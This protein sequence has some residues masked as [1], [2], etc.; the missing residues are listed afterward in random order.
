MDWNK[1]IKIG[2]IGQIGEDIASEYL[3]KNSWKILVRNY[4]GKLG[5]ID[6]VA[7]RG[8]KTLVFFEI[9]TIYNHE[10]SKFM[11]E[12]NLSMAKLKKLQRICQIF[13]DKNPMLVDQEK[14]WRIDLLAIDIGS[15]NKATD[16]RHYENIY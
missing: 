5:E 11:P 13:I 8:D 6:I 16:I 14:G 9:K 4:R 7:V 15:D 10:F 2:K 1:N 12:D 3:I